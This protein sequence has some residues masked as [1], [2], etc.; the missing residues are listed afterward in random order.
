MSYTFEQKVSGLLL[1][2]IVLITAY[3]VTTAVLGASE[4]ELGMPKI[5]PVS[6][7]LKCPATHFI[8]QSGRGWNPGE[9][10]TVWLQAAIACGEKFPK[11][12]CPKTI[13]KYES[14]GHGIACGEALTEVKTQGK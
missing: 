12:P 14:G 8:D 9:E 2:V 7:E 5:T 3:A 10:E 13:Y 1:G 11:S 6:E 4:T